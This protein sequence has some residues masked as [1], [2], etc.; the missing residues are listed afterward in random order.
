M[1]FSVVEKAALQLIRNDLRFANSA[2]H[3]RNGKIDGNYT[4]NFLP[5]M[6]LITDGI[7]DWIN[8]YN[9]THKTVQIPLTFTEEERIFYEQMRS[10]IKIWN[11]PYDEIY[12][13]IYD[14]YNKS[15]Y[16]FSSICVPIAKDLHLY[17]IWGAYIVNHQYCGN[18]ILGNYYLP[19]WSYY[20]P[21]YGEKL[22]KIS[23]ISGRYV[24][25]F[26]AESP[27]TVQSN[28]LF[29]NA[30]YGGF[31]KSPLG[32]DFSDRFVLFCILCQINFVLR[33]INEYVLD[34]ITTKLR[35]AY[36]LYYYLL[37][38]IPEIN[39]KL[40]YNFILDSRWHSDQFRN[41]MA[42]YKLGVALKEEEIIP[43]DPFMGLTQKYFNINYHQMKESIILLLSQL[44][45]QLTKYLQLNNQT[46]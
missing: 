20:D 25:L 22:K 1:E 10:A 6:G 8:A 37:K 13:K 27:L 32:D 39:T 16:Y 36:I 44:S 3:I 17:N 46:L 42:H 18:T 5:Y 2:I 38:I 24:R 31:I 43:S 33:C 23:Q 4:V 19:G 29:K 34:E 40:G 28:M 21:T 7:E 41:A 12:N 11:N 45:D 35:I 26:G 30:D 14:L 15:N 9:N